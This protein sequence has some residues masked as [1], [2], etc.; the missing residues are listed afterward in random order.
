MDEGCNL[1]VPVHVLSS[2]LAVSSTLACFQLSLI[3]SKNNTILHLHLQITLS[4]SMGG[5][6]GEGRGSGRVVICLG[7]LRKGL[8]FAYGNHT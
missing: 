1:Q 4:D 7:G 6:G 8:P 5:G 2:L 3:S